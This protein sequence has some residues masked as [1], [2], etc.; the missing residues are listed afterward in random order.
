MKRYLAL[1]SFLWGASF[2]AGWHVFVTLRW[3]PTPA[4]WMSIIALLTLMLAVLIAV[5]PREKNDGR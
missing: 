5:R 2:A 1:V 3:K 4:D